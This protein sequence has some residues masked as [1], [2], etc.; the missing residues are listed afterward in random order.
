MR[1]SI[2]WCRFRTRS[3]PWEVL[4]ALR[5][6]FGTVAPLLSLVDAG[7]GRD[8]WERRQ[9]IKLAGDL[10]LGEIDYGGE[11]QRGWVRVNFPGK[12][13]EWVQDWGAFA[14][15]GKGLIDAEPRRVDVA[16]TTFDG[17]VTHETVLDAHAKGLFSAGGRSPKLR[18][19]TGS[20]PLDGRTVYVGSRESE[21]FV[22]CYEKGRELL[23][24]I[25]VPEGVKKQV[26]KIEFDRV[27]MV[28]VDKIY[29]CEVEFKSSSERVIPWTI[30]QTP[31]S[32]FAGANPFFASL[33]PSVVSRSIQRMPDFD[34]RLALLVQA[35]NLRIAYGGVLRALL[36]AYDNDLA[37][38]MSMV[39]AD[40][41]SERLVRDGVLTVSHH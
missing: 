27:G 6:S 14:N 28:D 30:L 39:T 7:S 5:P 32:F 18:Q 1:I 29:R 23:N 2:D 41:P 10:Q 16:L 22:R 19:V 38:V 36:D 15:A 31:Q 33:V 25:G 9:L 3:T 12:G 11:T 4:E 20:D 26:Q 17:S 21:K 37:L 24:K 35:E 40:R 8:G 13:C 34:S